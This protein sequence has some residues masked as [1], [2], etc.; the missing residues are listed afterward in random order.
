MKNN[1]YLSAAAIRE[2]STLRPWVGISRILLEYIGIA[3]A[4]AI[5]LT[6]WSWPLYIFTV[7]WIGARILALAVMLH[8]GLHYLLHPNPRINDQI[9]RWLLAL[10][11]FLIVGNVRKSHFTHHKYTL[12]DKDPH[13]HRYESDAQWQFPK[14]KW[15]LL[16]L[17]LGDITGINMVH[18][19]KKQYAPQLRKDVPKKGGFKLSIEAVLYGL[20]FVSS[21][22]FG[23]WQEILLFW[24]VPIFTW[25]GFIFRLREI[26]EHCGFDYSEDL[27][28]K[29]RTVTASWLEQLF[30]SPANI[31]YHNEHHLFPS[32]PFYNLK[33]VHRALMEHPDFK[34]RAKV[35]NSY[36][37]VIKD[38][39]SVPE[40]E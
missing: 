23:F 18:F 1:G 4:I 22:Y 38:C 37:G 30:L 31:S 20:L 28:T 2:F 36:A 33:K 14:S 25:F 29:S 34:S 24:F 39:M 15:A 10:P 3:L 5:C 21:V 27:V 13:L 11:L 19:I 7:I 12:T 32:V 17:F 6:F 8:E 26:G 9:S 35:S 16:K 40:A